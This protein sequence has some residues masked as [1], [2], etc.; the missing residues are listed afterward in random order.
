MRGGTNRL[1][2]SF[3]INFPN[4][5]NKLDNS[6]QKIM[7]HRACNLLR[8]K[9]KINIKTNYSK[10]DKLDSIPKPF[11]ISLDFSRVITRLCKGI[12]DWTGR[13]GK[14]EQNEPQE[15]RD[16]HRERNLSL[17]Q[18]NKLVRTG[19]AISSR[20]EIENRKNE[21]VTLG[22]DRRFSRSRPSPIR[23]CGTSWKKSK[24]GN[25]NA[26]LHGRAKG[27]S[28][29][30]WNEEEKGEKG[31]GRERKGGRMAKLDGGRLKRT[32]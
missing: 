28:S 30:V 24:G 21:V 4:N 22:W 13:Q 29:V 32:E 3:Y 2:T 27:E 8:I 12:T 25:C 19:G 23:I 10:E 11:P 31:D 9:L 7:S 16:Y 5:S 20:I 15:S 18:R 26:L 14:P 6:K 17:S 1:N